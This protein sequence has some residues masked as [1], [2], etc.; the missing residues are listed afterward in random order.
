MLFI[1]TDDAL[2]RLDLDIVNADGGD[3]KMPYISTVLGADFK[4]EAPGPNAN[5]GCR[6]SIEKDVG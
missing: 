1:F 6:W 4:S 2:A 3:T 5:S